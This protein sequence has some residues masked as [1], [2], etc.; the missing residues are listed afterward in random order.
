MI[1]LTFIIAVVAL[2]IAIVAYRRTDGITD[3][4]GG[5]D[6]LDSVTDSIKEKTADAL[7][8]MEKSLRKTEKEEGD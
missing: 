4:K 7:G 6:S 1:G 2:A 8:K 5:G 3:L